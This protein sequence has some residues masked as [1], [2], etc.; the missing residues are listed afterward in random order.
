[1]FIA[2]SVLFRLHESPRFLQANKRTKEAAHILDQIAVYN[3]VPDYR[4]RIDVEEG[5]RD[6]QEQERDLSPYRQDEDRTS[7]GLGK[8]ITLASVLGYENGNTPPLHT[9]LDSSTRIKVAHKPLYTHSLD[10]PSTPG[11]LEPTSN[12]PRSQFYTPSEELSGFDW[13]MAPDKQNRRSSV[14]SGPPADNQILEEGDDKVVDNGKEG[15]GGDRGEDVMSGYEAWMEK[16]Q[17]MFGPKW[18]RTTTLMWAIWMMMSLG[19]FC[20]FDP[21]RWILLTDRDT[22]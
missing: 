7:I 10:Q 11:L 2:R 17:I 15:Y 21:A 18:R 5:D 16:F 9:R 12:R 13:T 4:T 20:I 8:P 6:D 19:K 22:L 1:M 14:L 3:Q